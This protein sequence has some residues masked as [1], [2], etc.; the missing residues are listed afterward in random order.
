MLF[1]GTQRACFLLKNNK[2]DLLVI[3]LL[4]I[5]ILLYVLKLTQGKHFVL[6]SGVLLVCEPGS[7]M[8][9]HDAMRQVWRQCHPK[10]MVSRTFTLTSNLVWF[11]FRQTQIKLWSIPVLL[12]EFL[13][14]G[15]IIYKRGKMYILRLVHCI[16]KSFSISLY[17]N[18]YSIFCQFKWDFKLIVQ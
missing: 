18:I 3:I 11:V 12:F 16:K 1:L 2:S 14:Q 8:V 6:D 9:C 17:L 4:C 7:N 10:I 13:V 5:W 15:Q